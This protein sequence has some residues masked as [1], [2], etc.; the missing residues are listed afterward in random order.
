M[1]RYLIKFVSK[2]SHAEDLRSGKLFMRPA[3]YYHKLEAGQGD[4]AEAAISHYAMIYKNSRLPI[5]CMYAVKDEEICQ[6]GSVHI[7]Q[8]LV[9]EFDCTQGYAVVVS[10]DIFES[11]LSTVRTEGYALYSGEI[12][13]GNQPIE[14]FPALLKAD[15][16]INLFNKRPYFKHQNEFRVVICCPVPKNKEKKARRKR[17]RRKKKMR[18]KE[19]EKIEYSFQ[20]D[21]FDC[22]H[23]V[24]LANS[25]SDDGNYIIPLKEVNFNA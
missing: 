17:I 18:K 14:A 20:S 5:Y 8:Q 16:P 1:S 25:K 24:S 4:I 7:P 19:D 23:I 11:R 12:V 9:E 10:R 13:Y 6:D 2:L 21:L 15:K 3:E 22:T